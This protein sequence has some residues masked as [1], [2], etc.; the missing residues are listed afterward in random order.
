MKKAML[1]E[2]AK[3]L[4][5]TGEF[6]NESGNETWKNCFYKLNGFL[7]NI[8]YKNGRLFDVIAYGR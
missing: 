3:Q 2:K 4:I 5:E 6:I 8:Q 7:F 1:K